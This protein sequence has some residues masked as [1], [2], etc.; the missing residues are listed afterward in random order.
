V[1]LLPK[2]YAFAKIQDDSDR[3]LRFWTFDHISVATEATCICFKIGVVIDI[4]HNRFIVTQNP[5]LPKFKMAAA[6][7]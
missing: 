1:Q 5:T 2:N 7:T 4:D 6:A 3:H